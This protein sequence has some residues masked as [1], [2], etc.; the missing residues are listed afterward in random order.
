MNINYAYHIEVDGQ[1]IF[2]GAELQIKIK[3]SPKI[4]FGVL[5]QIGPSGI[6][7][8][9]PGNKNNQFINFKKIESI[10]WTGGEEED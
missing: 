2:L 3:D 9:F 6:Y 5:E 8:L 1:V 4:R 7:V 10:K